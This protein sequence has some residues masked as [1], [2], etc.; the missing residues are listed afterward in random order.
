MAGQPCPAD[1]K[2]ASGTACIEDTSPCA[3]D[4]WDGTH[5][6]CQ[7][8]AGNAGAECR[9]AAGPC[10]V[11]E[12]CDGTSTDCPDDA[13][14]LPGTECRAAAGDCDIA[15]TCDGSGDKCPANA[16]KPAT[17]TCRP[18]V[19]ECDAAERCTGT[20]AHCPADGKQPPRTAS[21]PD[22]NP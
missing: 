7:H 5:D 17:T 11:A 22:G 9:A 4:Q 18:A 14:Q 8:P 1:E 15:A 6:T 16:F 2:K 3:L 20:T 21:G 12:M 13:K 10:D 19:D